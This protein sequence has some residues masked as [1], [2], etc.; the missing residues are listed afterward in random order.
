MSQPPAL[1]VSYNDMYQSNLS[2]ISYLKNTIRKFN[3]QHM[4]AFFSYWV[5]A[6]QVEND[7]I[8]KHL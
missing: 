2:L 1:I 4:S 7:E 3:N 8:A 6:L 5:A